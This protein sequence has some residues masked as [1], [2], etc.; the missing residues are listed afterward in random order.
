MMA[1]KV[2]TTYERKAIPEKVEQVADSYDDFLPDSASV[3]ERRKAEKDAIDDRKMYQKANDYDEF[4]PESELRSFSDSYIGTELA[5]GARTVA[6]G[7]SAGTSDELE[8]GITALFS[9]TPYA[10][11]RANILQDLQDQRTLRPTTAL[12]QD[13]AGGVLGGGALVSQMVKRGSSVATAGALEGGLMGAG[14][15]EGVEGKLAG[16]AGFAAFG[17]TL[18]RAVDWAT[19]PS[20]KAMRSTK[21]GGRTQADDIYD[22]ETLTVTLQNVLFPGIPV[23]Y[24]SPVG[25]L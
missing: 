17:G 3:K 12:F 4:L 11:A 7:L 21:E 19:T 6:Q 23:I 24:K 1:T 22:E 2:D 18:G 9:D 20:S 13:I 25:A 14:Y 16:T 8:A 5:R 10:D 15:G